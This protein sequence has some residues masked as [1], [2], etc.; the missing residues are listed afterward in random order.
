MSAK[1]DSTALAAL[2]RKDA[3]AVADVVRAHAGDL[4]RAGYGMGLQ[5]AEAEDLVSDTFSTFLKVVERFEGRSSVRTY[6][7]GI[8]YRKALERGRKRSRELA[9]DPIDDVFNKRF[10]GMGTW[11]SP[12]KG[13]EAEAMS[14]EAEKLIGECMETLSPTQKAAF[15]LK[16]IDRQPSGSVRNILDVTDTHLRVLLF[17]AKNKLRECLEKKWEGSG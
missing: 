14:H 12:P 2:R 1:L 10:T 8:L 9:T 5:S 3:Q 4:L 16:V 15:Y 11:S 7:F 17:R 6:L 13:P